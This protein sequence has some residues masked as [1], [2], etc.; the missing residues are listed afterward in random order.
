MSRPVPLFLAALSA[1]L[2]GSKVD[3][4]REH[5][6]MSGP[7]ERPAERHVRHFPRVPYVPRVP[8]PDEARAISEA[9]EKRARKAAK[10]A[11]DA[12]RVAAGRKGGA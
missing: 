11:R 6:P 7:A 4:V 3:E 2:A 8:P 10:R 9:E 12:E 5:D 1:I